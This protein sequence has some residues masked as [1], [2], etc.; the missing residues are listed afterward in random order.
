MLTTTSW[1]A[2]YHFIYTNQL[3][4]KAVY[5]GHYTYQHIVAIVDYTL[6]G[7]ATASFKDLVTVVQEN[8]TNQT[9]EL[10]MG[11][12]SA[13]NTAWSPYSGYLNIK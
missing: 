3:I 1:I 2:F 8:S 9:A 10:S 13:Y 4:L 5:F 12:R 11:H 7:S 6:V